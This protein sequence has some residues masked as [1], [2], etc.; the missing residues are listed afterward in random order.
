VYSN[1]AEAESLF[2]S[3]LPCRSLSLCHSLTLSSSSVTENTYAPRSRLHRTSHANRTYDSTVDVR[4]RCTPRHDTTVVAVSVASATPRRGIP[5]FRSP[6]D[7][8]RSRGRR[9]TTATVANGCG[10]GRTAGDA[11]VRPPS[12]AV[13]R[14]KTVVPSAEKV[15]EVMAEEGSPT[16]CRRPP[17]RTRPKRS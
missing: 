17:S 9:W 10:G 1:T 3:L 15:W 2:F 16:N 6:H 12:W 11:R 5:F 7:C 8:S 13:T 14:A 4:R